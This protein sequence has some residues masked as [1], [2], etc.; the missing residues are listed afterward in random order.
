MREGKKNGPQRCV[1]QYG[2]I[3]FETY[4]DDKPHGLFIRVFG[5]TINVD[6]WREGD[7]IFK[8]SFTPKGEETSRK[9]DENQFTN[10]N[11]LTFFK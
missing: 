4:K 11:T 3:L 10:I 5:D 2:D 8:L 9:D 1:N 7:V 6:V